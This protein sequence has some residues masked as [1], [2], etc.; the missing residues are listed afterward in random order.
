M[1]NVGNVLN[2]LL[3]PR[4]VVVK[5][6]SLLSFTDI[7]RVRTVCKDVKS[8]AEDTEIVKVVDKLDFPLRLIYTNSFVVFIYNFCF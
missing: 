6:I 3:L 1:D 4:D 7:M 5:I 8:I 2:F